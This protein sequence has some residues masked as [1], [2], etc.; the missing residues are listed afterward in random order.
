MGDTQG[1]DDYDRSLD[2]RACGQSLLVSN[3]DNYKASL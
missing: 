1:V 2:Q 3:T